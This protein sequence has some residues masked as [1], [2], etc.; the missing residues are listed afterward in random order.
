MR[1]A[2]IIGWMLCLMIRMVG[3]APLYAVE[4]RLNTDTAAQPAVGESTVAEADRQ[5]IQTV[6]LERVSLDKMRR[7][8]LLERD[9]LEQT[10]KE[11]EA[12]IHDLKQLREEVNA[13]ISTLQNLEEN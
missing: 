4:K 5:L 3:P 9:R 7:D 1:T 11:I 12:R 10:R 8:I 2:G 6:S 13:K